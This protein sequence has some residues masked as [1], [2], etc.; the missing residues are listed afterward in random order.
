MRKHG[1]GTEKVNSCG[2]RV[3]HH[4]GA[5]LVVSHPPA[6]EV[7]ACPCFLCRAVWMC[8][9]LRGVVVRCAVL[10]A[11]DHPSSV[12]PWGREW[13]LCGVWSLWGGCGVSPMGDTALQPQ[14][15]LPGWDSNGLRPHAWETMKP[16]PSVGSSGRGVPPILG[17]AGHSEGP[18]ATEIPWISE[19]NPPSLLSPSS[20]PRALSSTWTLALSGGSSPQGGGP[21]VIPASS[22]N[23]G[24]WEDPCQHPSRQ[25]LRLPLHPGGHWLL[26]SLLS[27]L[28]EL[29]L[30]DLLLREQTCSPE[31]TWN[32]HHS[33]TSRAWGV[34]IGAFEL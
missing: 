28:G 10:C 33:F 11:G 3:C 16:H 30:S 1:K 29:I 12:C 18:G 8:C 2:L 23:P 34:C 24:S 25:C 27:V 21:A 5:A 4:P 19:P 14:H 26:P 20:A 22:P 32:T 31:E 7:Q 13:G 17:H 6:V 15:Q 9:C